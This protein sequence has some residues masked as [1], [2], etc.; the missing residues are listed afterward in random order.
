MDSVTH[1]VLSL[2]LNLPGADEAEELVIHL[3][4]GRYH[5]AERI[6][7]A[8]ELPLA[9]GAVSTPVL[10]S[11]AVL[12]EIL[13]QRSFELKR[14]RLLMR[15]SPGSQPRTLWRSRP[16]VLEL[17]HAGRRVHVLFY[18]KEDRCYAAPADCAN[19]VAGKLSITIIDADLNGCFSDPTDCLEWNEGGLRMLGTSPAVATQRGIACVAIGEQRTGIEAKLTWDKR[20]LGPSEGEWQALWQV[21]WL[22]N[23][24]GLAPVRMDPARNDACRAHAEYLQLHYPG[25]TPSGVSPH[26]EDSSLIGSSPLGALAARG[27]ISYSSENPDLAHQVEYEFA[28][29]FHRGE[30]LYPATVMGAALHRRYTVVWVGEQPGDSRHWL[31][32]TQLNGAFTMVPAPGQEDVP[33]FAKPD[34]PIPASVPDFYAKP[35]GWPISVA[36]TF[37]SQELG[38]VSLRLFDDT[39]EALP[40]FLI[41]L[42]DA[43]LSAPNLMALYSFATAEPLRPKRSYRAEFRARRQVGTQNH[44]LLYSWSFTTGR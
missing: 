3:S 20:P 24:A 30:Y 5:A 14:G 16:E 2:L 4:T 28:K 34:S 25:G 8:L 1:C 43:G 35:R 37:A 31:D 41:T 7:F 11:Q 13:A 33:L 38:D 12:A 19:G 21:N 40:G 27:N 9:S 39:G 17:P 6:P 22:R 36:A 32:G 42:A 18:T 23:E 29:L 10:R 44:D 15:E 26:V